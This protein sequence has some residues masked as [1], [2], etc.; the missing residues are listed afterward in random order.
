[1]YSA[2]LKLS[3]TNIYVKDI[4][5]IPDKEILDLYTIEIFVHNPKIIIT[6]SM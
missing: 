1:M 6:L 2:P 5:C 3:P 4:F